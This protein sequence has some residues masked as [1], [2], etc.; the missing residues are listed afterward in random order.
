M[1]YS[2]TIKFQDVEFCL[3][4]ASLIESICYSL[5]EKGADD[6]IVAL[7]EHPSSKVQSVLARRDAIP[8]EALMILAKSEK[9]TVRRSLASSSSF[10]SWANTELLIEWSSVDEEFARLVGDSISDYESA[11][12]NELFAALV[13]HPDPDVRLALADTYGLPKGMRK[14][15]L[16]DADNGVRLAAERSM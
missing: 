1:T 2:M 12:L 6:I 11:D 10:R 16:D 13:A 5:P 15:L 4:E 8:V 7:A 3:N 9:I 14:K